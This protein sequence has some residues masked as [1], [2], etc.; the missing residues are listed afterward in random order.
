MG[1]LG[2]VEQFADSFANGL[3]GRPPIEP[4][5]AFIPEDKRAFQTTQENR[6]MRHVK[7]GGLLSDRLFGSLPGRS[8]FGLL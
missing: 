3:L 8:P 5:G 6:I 2:H 1:L 4:L 7:E